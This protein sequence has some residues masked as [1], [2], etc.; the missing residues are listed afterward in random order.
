LRAIESVRRGL[1][2]GT[3]NKDRYPSVER[4]RHL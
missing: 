1:S 3:F 2:E 4:E